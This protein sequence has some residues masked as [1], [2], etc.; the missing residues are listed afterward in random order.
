VTEQRGA[1][2]EGADCTI[3]PAEIRRLAEAILEQTSSRTRVFFYNG[4][5][6]KGEDDRGL[7]RITRRGASPRR[8]QVLGRL[9][10]FSPNDRLSVV[11]LTCRLQPV[12]V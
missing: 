9:I 2:C 1:I 4:R 7:Y 11:F 12:V 5:G 6:S 8:Y 10:G 3:D